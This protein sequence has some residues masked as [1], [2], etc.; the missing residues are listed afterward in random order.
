MDSPLT[1]GLS[2]VKGHRVA[3]I[4]RAR[5]VRVWS[6]VLLFFAWPLWN[7]WKSSQLSAWNGSMSATASAVPAQ[8]LVTRCRG[9]AF[10]TS[11]PIVRIRQVRAEEEAVQVDSATSGLRSNPGEKT[12]W[13][14]E[15]R[16]AMLRA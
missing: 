7:S 15:K 16:E 12:T 8:W 1:L 2:G 6:W 14:P 10:L 9:A 5:C 4:S 13:L 11:W 3:G